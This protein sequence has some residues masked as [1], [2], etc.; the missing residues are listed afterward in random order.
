MGIVIIS[1][2]GASFEFSNQ[3]EHS[4]NNQVKYQA[5]LR[6]LQ[7]LQEAGAEIIEIVGDSLLVIKQLVGEYE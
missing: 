3:V 7:F 2:R 6:G 4:T 1:P 5:V